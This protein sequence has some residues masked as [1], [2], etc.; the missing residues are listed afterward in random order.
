MAVVAVLAALILAGIVAAKKRVRQAHCAHNVGQI[1]LC[2]QLF[3]TDNHV[4]PLAVNPN[5][6]KG[7]YPE[8]QTVWMTALEALLARGRPFAPSLTEP[9]GKGVWLCPSA[10]RPSS[11][12]DWR[13]YVSYGYN[14]YGLSTRGTSLGLG[15]Q[16]VWLGGTDGSAPPVRDS[17]VVSPSQLILLGDGFKGGKG[18]IDDG[19]DVLS[20]NDAVQDY[21]GSTVR[22]L[23]RHQQKANVVF[24][25][26]HVEAPTLRFLFEDNTDT[27]LARWNRDNR[28][29]R[30]LLTP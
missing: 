11:F 25:D 7:E 20:R 30:D 23:A 9:I 19:L 2:V 28:P 4:Y 24:S 12:P 8:H 10:S 21:L 15:G 18:I 3:V 16:N 13:G 1:G 26:G 29:H 22:A 14:P 5:Y 17:E 27:A 6:S